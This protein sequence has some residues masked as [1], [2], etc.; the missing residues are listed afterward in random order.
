MNNDNNTEISSSTTEG[1]IIKAVF[2]IFGEL[3]II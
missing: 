1:E 3:L 2:Y